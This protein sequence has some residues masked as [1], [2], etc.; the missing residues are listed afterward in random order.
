MEY[1]HLLKNRGTI[2]STGE[3]VTHRDL[4]LRLLA[5]IQPPHEV[6]VCK[7][8]AHVRS[9]DEVSVGNRKADEAVKSKLH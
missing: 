2:R 5:A 3:P 8:A 1:I 9:T 4:L 7:C 6:A